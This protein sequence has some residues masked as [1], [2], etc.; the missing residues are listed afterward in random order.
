VHHRDGRGAQSERGGAAARPRVGW[1]G[2]GGQPA[3]ALPRPVLA[4]GVRGVARVS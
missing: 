4:G 3:A 2:R 1:Q